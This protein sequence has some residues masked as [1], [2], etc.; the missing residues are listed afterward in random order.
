MQIKINNLI[1]QY[2]KNT[3]LN[4]PELSVYPGELVG[5]VGNNGAGK[6]TLMRLMLDLIEATEGTVELGKYRVDEDA[7]W[8]EATGSF[9]DGRFLIDFYTPEEYFGFIAQ[10]Y[11]IDKETL[12]SRLAAYHS[13]MH[14]EILGT[15]KYLRQFSEGN[16]QKIGIIGAMQMEIAALRDRMEGELVMQAA[17]EIAKRPNAVSGEKS[18]QTLTVTEGRG[19]YRVTDAKARVMEVPQGTAAITRRLAQTLGVSVGDTV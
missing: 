18:T 13:L 3:V 11:H 19:L 2:G 17:I 15:K 12:D 14:D 8:K 16:R 9:I 7:T 4:I 6:T 1:K 5:L 10:A